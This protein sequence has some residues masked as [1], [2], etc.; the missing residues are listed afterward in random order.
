MVLRDTTASTAEIVTG[1]YYPDYDNDSGEY[2]GFDKY[3]I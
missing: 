1:N 2:D 3:L